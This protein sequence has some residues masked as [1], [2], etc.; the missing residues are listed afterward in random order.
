MPCLPLERAKWAQ[1][2]EDH[3]SLQTRLIETESEHNRT[4][5]AREESHARELLDR[6]DALKKRNGR[7]VELTKAQLRGE[8]RA[9]GARDESAEELEVIL[10]SA[11]GYN[12]DMEPFVKNADGSPKSS[13]TASRKVSERS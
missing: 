6:A 1:I 10:H 5:K 7:I 9:A 2:E 11:I 13:S 3:K 12:D 4:L 8:A